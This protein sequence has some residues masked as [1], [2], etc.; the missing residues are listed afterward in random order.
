MNEIKNNIYLKKSEKVIEIQSGKKKEKKNR[1]LSL[2][3]IQ[4]IVE[5]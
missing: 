5:K 2:I 4:I 3:L 1:A